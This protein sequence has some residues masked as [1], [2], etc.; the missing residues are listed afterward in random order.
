MP[1][2]KRNGTDTNPASM[3]QASSAAQV[4]GRKRVSVIVWRLHVMRRSEG[5]EAAAATLSAVAGNLVLAPE[6]PGEAAP[7][8]DQGIGHG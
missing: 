5:R 4:A 8:T 1:K 6:L 3:T 7:P 2:T